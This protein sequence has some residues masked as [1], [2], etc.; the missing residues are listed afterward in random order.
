MKRR[1]FTAK[2]ASLASLT[3]LAAL[4]SGAAGCGSLGDVNHKEPLAILQGQLTQSAAASTAA[5]S[6]VRIAVLWMNVENSSYRATQDIQAKAV[7]PSQFRLELTDP[8]PREAIATRDTDTHGDDPSP[9]APSE[10]GSGGM[11]PSPD[12]DTKSLGAGH[13]K[14]QSDASRWPAG[15]GVAYG[16]VVAYE[17]K[18]GNGKLDLVDDG[19]ASYTD[20]ILGANDNLALVYIEGTAPADFKDK[21]GHM[22][23]AGFNLIKNIGGATNCETDATLKGASLQP[24]GG[25]TPSGGPEWLGMS[26]LYDLPLTAD[27]RFA[28]L[29]CKSGGG[30]AGEGSASIAQV[31][32]GPGPNGKY[33]AA[34]DPALVCAP[35]ATTYS[36]SECTRIDRGLCR[37]TIESCK[38]TMWKIPGGGS[39]PPAGWPCTAKS[40]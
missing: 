33:P 6:N 8:P 7:F 24:R 34:N 37:G 29:M 4:A 20:R 27:P 21:N 26:T 15:F 31:A 5:P 28:E 18:N 39:T 17:D 36:Y 14:A 2:S 38:Y 40:N 19:A 25:C 12:P 35:D 1:I 22:P 11:Q 9:V 30:N 16:A 23:S 10:P 13:L 32:E 3:A